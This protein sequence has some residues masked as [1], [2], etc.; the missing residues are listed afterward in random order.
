ML[1]QKLEYINLAKS[2]DAALL[3]YFLTLS[4]QK[5]KLS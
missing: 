1:K 4:C 2:S 3:L 5:A